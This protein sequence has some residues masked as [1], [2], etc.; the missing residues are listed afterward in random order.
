MKLKEYIT[1]LSK[2]VEENSEV[3]NFEVVYSIDEEGNGFGQIF[4][5]PTLGVFNDGEFNTDMDIEYK[6]AVCI[7]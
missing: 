4:Y 6:N 2:L 7:N 5:D 3:G 1:K